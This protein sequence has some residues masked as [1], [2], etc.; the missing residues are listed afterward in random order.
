MQLYDAHGAVKNHIKAIH[1]GV[2]DNLLSFDKKLTGLTEKQNNLLKDIADG[3][4]DKEIAKKNDIS[5]AT[6]RHQRFMFREKAKQAK[7]YLAIFDL[8]ELSS[9]KNPN[10]KLLNPHSGA[11]MVDERY[12]LANEEQD[13]IISTYFEGRETLILKSFPA[14]EK[15]KIAV[16]RKI[17]EQFEGSREYP[18]KE[19]N[20][21]LKT[22][23]PDIATIRRYL[24]EYG[25]LERTKD[26]KSYWVKWS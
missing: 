6:V 11:K 8:V 5:P 19:V 4:S 24:I 1:K 18:E 16:L 3:L 7:I 2:L 23:Y 25:F 20:E 9:S 15:R 10:E 13:K 12:I 21:I 22:I 14:K 26:C 17:T